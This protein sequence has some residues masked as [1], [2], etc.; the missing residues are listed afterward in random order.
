MPVK[1]AISMGDPNG[2]GPEIILKTLLTADLKETIPVIYGRDDIFKQTLSSL[3]ESRS[4]SIIDSAQDAKAGDIN[5]VSCVDRSESELTIGSIS[6]AGGLASMKAVEAGIDACLSGETSALVTA[7]IS[8][9]AITLGGYD[10]PGHTEFLMEKTSSDQ[11]LMMLVS[12]AFRVALA[13]IHIPVRD[14]VTNLTAD[15][16]KTRLKILHQALQNDFGIANPKIAVMGLNPHGGDGGVIGREEIELIQPVINQINDNGLNLRG[17]FAADGFFGKSMHN[18][19]DAVFAMYHDQG[20]IPFKALTFGRGVNVTA[21][22]PIIRTSP[23]H[24]T[25][26]DIAGKNLADA[27][28]F[29][30]A[31]SLA[32]TLAEQKKSKT[33]IS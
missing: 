19:F 21:G 10:V 30:A 4:I 5:L 12:D 9:E 13:T 14:I 11:V 26:F 23:D 18:E 24:G 16:L 8:K 15:L 3:D 25:A 20:L 33:T 17:P 32:A 2:I 31:Y 29:K 22:L 1:I 7:P 27:E 6:A 28:S